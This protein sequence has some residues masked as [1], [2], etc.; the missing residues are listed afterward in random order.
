M[1]R[2]RGFQSNRSL[3]SQGFGVAEILLRDV[4]SIQAIQCAQDAQHAAIPA[5]QRD[6]Q[7]LFC[8]EGGEGAEIEIGGPIVLLR[9]ECFPTLQRAREWAFGYL[10]LQR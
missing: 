8:L 4:S 3:G 5:Y 9:P 10:N 1:Q 6:G 2:K 7:N